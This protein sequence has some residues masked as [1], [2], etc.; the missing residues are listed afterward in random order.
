MIR[1]SDQYMVGP[2]EFLLDASCIS[3]SAAVLVLLVAEVYVN[4]GPCVINLKENLG[5]FAGNPSVPR[6]KFALRGAFARQI[7]RKLIKRDIN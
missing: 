1:L 4:K 5:H 7:E 6:F 3:P 2:S